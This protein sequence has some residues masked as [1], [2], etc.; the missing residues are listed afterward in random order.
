[1]YF[2]RNT[3]LALFVISTVIVAILSQY[4]SKKIS[5]PITTLAKDLNKFDLSREKVDEIAIET[6]SYELRQLTQRFNELIKRTND[7]FTF[8]KHTIH[9]ISHQLKT[10]IAI[11][12]SELEKIQNRCTTEPIKGEIGNQ[13][14]KTKSLGN[15][16]HVILEVSKIE[17]GQKIRKLPTRIDEM[18]FDTIEELNIIYQD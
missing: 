13:I 1:M 2:L 17:S 3:L 5:T 6:S 10:P 11:L 8:Q 9:H 14:I 12:V 18:I 4:F 16:I 7:A 15:I